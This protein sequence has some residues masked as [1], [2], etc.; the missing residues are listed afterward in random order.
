M[1]AKY[2]ENPFYE[3]INP[4]WYPNQVLSHILACLVVISSLRRD[5]SIL[6]HMDVLVRLQS[7]DTIGWVLNTAFGLAERRSQ[8]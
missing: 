7:I 3:P 2:S 6:F 5:L 1:S 4:C 8:R